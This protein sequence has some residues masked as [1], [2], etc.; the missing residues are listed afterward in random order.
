MFAWRSLYL[1]YHI[2]KPHYDL[3]IFFLAMDKLSSDID[4]RHMWC[5]LLVGNIILFDES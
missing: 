3:I 2:Q 1:Q 5:M 4:D